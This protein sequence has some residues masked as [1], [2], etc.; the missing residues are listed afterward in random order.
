MLVTFSL[1]E[2]TG[3]PCFVSGIRLEISSNGYVYPVRLLI[4]L[5]GDFI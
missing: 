3:P 4:L 5:V 2:D 1:E